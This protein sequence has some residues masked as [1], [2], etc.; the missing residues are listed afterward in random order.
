MEEPNPPVS[1]TRIPFTP[2][3]GALAG[4]LENML[5]PMSTPEVVIGLGDTAWALGYLSSQVIQRFGTVR[6]PLSTLENLQVSFKAMV[7]Q[8]LP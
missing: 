2:N 1:P 6:E 7:L 4:E 3:F 8:A 5:M